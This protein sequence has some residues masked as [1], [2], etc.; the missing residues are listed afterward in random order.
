MATT[1][2]FALSTRVRDFRSRRRSNTSTPVIRGGERQSGKQ[3]RTVT[4]S[5]A[6]S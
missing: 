5:G 2:I 3:K 6:R 1:H 4:A